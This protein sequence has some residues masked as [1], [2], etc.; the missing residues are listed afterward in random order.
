MLAFQRKYSRNS[1][2]TNVD[3]KAKRRESEGEGDDDEGDNQAGKQRKR[4]GNCFGV[5]SKVFEVEVEE[6]RGKTLF[7]IVESK[8]G[9][10]SWVRLGPASGRLFLE[11]LDQCVK[12]GKEEKR[13]KGWKEKGR[14]Y[15]M[16][17]EA[18][19]AGCFLRLGVVDAEEKRYGIC[20]LKGKG[21]KGGWSV[22]AEVI[23]DLIASLD[24]KEKKKEELI[25][26]RMQAEMG[27]R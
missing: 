7:F 23:R 2:N 20:I 25:P 6:K 21:E 10:S 3:E 12:N 27:K 22:M 9:V 19:K 17:H 24:R 26:V 1:K 4:Q 16:V 11:G 8:R 14:S 15:S 13:E 18:N 5:E